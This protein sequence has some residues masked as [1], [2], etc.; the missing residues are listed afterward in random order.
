MENVLLS[1]VSAADTDIHTNLPRSKTTNQKK[2]NPEF[3]CTLTQL[4]CTLAAD[5]RQRNH[6]LHNCCESTEEQRKSLQHRG[7][8]ITEELSKA[9]GPSTPACSLG[10]K[11]IFWTAPVAEDNIFC[12]RGLRALWWEF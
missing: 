11:G 7:G 10:V 1:T 9:E 4:L 12:A 5:Q 3:G 8:A 2:G 6:Q